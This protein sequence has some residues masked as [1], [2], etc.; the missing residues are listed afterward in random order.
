MEKDVGWLDMRMRYYMD[1]DS[2]EGEF[3]HEIQAE[4][5]YQLKVDN[6]EKVN[7]FLH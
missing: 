7:V 2:I 1:K 5:T 3:L 6:A 4:N